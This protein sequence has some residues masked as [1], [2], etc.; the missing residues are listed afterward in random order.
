MVVVHKLTNRCRIGKNT[1]C[2]ITITTNVYCLHKRLY[3][4]KSMAK[5]FTRLFFHVTF[6]SKKTTTTI[7]VRSTHLIWLWSIWSHLRVA[8]ISLFLKRG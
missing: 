1:D 7:T 5:A 2:L 8:L 3:K 4:C 6:K